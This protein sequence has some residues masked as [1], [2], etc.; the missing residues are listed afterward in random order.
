MTVEYCPEPV[1][2]GPYQMVCGYRI[3]R[4]KCIR[5]GPVI[6]T[7]G[8]TDDADLI[9]AIEQAIALHVPACPNERRTQAAREAIRVVRLEQS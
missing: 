1:W 6:D 4:G 7:A 8:P 2:D 9:R 5:H 3:V